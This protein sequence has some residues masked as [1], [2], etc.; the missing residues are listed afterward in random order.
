MVRRGHAGEHVQP[1]EGLVAAAYRHRMSRALD[2]QLHTHVVAANLARGR[3][4]GSRPCMARSSTGRRRPRGTSTRR[5]SARSSRS[6]LAWSGGRSATVRRSWRR[7]SARWWS[8]SRSAVTRCCARPS[9]EG[10]ALGQ[11]AR[12]SKRRSPHGSASNTGLRRTRGGRRSGPAP[13]SRVSTRAGSRS[14]CRQAWSGW[15]VAWP[16]ATAWTSKRSVVGW[17]AQRV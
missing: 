1:G 9:G 16:S 13:T 14:C 6:V 15:S 4:A 5:I 2:P 11:R 7:S 12:P 3:T 17:W 8:I 10:S